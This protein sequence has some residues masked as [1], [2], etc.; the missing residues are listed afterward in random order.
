MCGEAAR[1][2]I[3]PGAAVNELRS[4]DSR[5]YWWDQNCWRDQTSWWWR[6]A[7][8]DDARRAAKLLADITEAARTFK[9]LCGRRPG[10]RNAGVLLHV[11]S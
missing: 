5:I 8:A 10:D 9:T 2:V 11:V 1:T 3:A 7:T 6:A 4:G